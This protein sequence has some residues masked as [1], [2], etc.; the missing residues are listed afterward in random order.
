MISEG[1]KS[2]LFGCH[3]FVMHPLMVTLAWRKL[4]GRWPA[5]WQLVCIFLHDV[6]HL[7]KDYL[8]HFELKKDHWRLGAEIAGWLFGWDAYWFT[9]WHSKSSNGDRWQ[10]NKLF[11][12]D[13]YSWLIA[14]RWWLR[15]ND[16]VEGF[17]KD[18]SL[19]E[20]L[21]T[22]RKNWEAGCPKGSH[23]IYLDIKEAS[24][25]TT[26]ISASAKT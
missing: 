12:A 20:W 19:D 1:T 8:T 18:R 17:G 16:K 23:Q 3:Q 24:N 14:P 10:P 15:L 22:M 25:G 21:T 4:N 6:G 13:K 11:W 26:R 2:L 5:L 9:R 7:G